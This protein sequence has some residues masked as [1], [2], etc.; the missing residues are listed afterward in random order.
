LDSFALKVYS[1]NI[2]KNKASNR[3]RMRMDDKILKEEPAKMR[4]KGINA[5]LL[6]WIVCVLL[7]EV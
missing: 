6:I 5:L 4:S 7:V 3:K 1:V 2:I